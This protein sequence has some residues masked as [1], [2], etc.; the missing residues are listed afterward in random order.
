MAAELVDVEAAT[1][2]GTAAAVSPTDA[3]VWTF[4]TAARIIEFIAADCRGRGRPAE[5]EEFEAQAARFIALAQVMPSVSVSRV[6]S[7]V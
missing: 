2:L 1:P 7:K 5:A 4:S 6:T 3:L